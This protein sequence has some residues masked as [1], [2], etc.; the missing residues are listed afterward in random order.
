MKIARYIAIAAVGLGVIA[1]AH[2]TTLNWSITSDNAFALYMST[3][4]T[5]AGSLIYS[6]LGN[7]STAGQ[8]N[9]AFTGSVSVS[10]IEYINIVGYN[11]TSSNGL[12]TSPG[13]A[14]G[15]GDNPVA[16][17]GSFSLTGG[18]GSFSNGNTSLVT[19]TTNWA[20]IN[21]APP[22]PDT[23]TT[24]P[25]PAWQTPT[26]TPVSDGMNGVAPWG[27]I[28]GIDSTAEWIWADNASPYEYAD[29]STAVSGAPSGGLASTPLPGTLPLL[30][31]GLGAL[32]L[33]GW[34][35]R[36]QAVASAG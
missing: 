30:A 23:P 13:T 32:G 34:R 26:G 20:A 2:A 7:M 12:W 27:H 28:T 29:F 25:N 1:P 31:S 21:V 24:A 9:T 14:N 5:T 16:L 35:R 33:F 3:S 19:N 10:G 8:W 4:D 6:N 36:R 11:Y 22:S 15:G 17:L 18:P